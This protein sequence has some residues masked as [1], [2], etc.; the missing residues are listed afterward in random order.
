M[1]GCSENKDVDDKVNQVIDNKYDIVQETY[2]DNNIIINYPQV[3]DL[4]D[5]EKQNK[6]NELIKV[7]ALKLLDDYKDDINN[8]TLNMDFEIMYKGSDIL[9]IQ[10]LGLSALKNAA[11]PIN[12]INTTNIDLVNVKLL[13]LSDVV[14]V[15]EQFIDRFKEGKYRPYSQ[16]LNLKSAGALND[17]L[18]GFGSNDLLANFKQ[19]TANFYFTDDS[20]VVSENV[21]HAMGDHFEMEIKYENLDNLLLIAPEK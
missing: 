21:I 6:I 16:D 14:T 15:N 1:S 17:A 7:S 12:E 20:I 19:E 11:Y 13:T 3:I 10:Y 4:G 18:N 9:S 5:S 2:T 8:L